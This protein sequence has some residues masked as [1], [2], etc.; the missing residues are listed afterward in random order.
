MALSWH[1]RPV[2][3]RRSAPAAG[4]PALAG[5]GL[6]ARRGGLVRLR[7]H[8]AGR[9]RPDVGGYGDNPLDLLYYDL[10]L[11]VLGSP[12]LDAGGPF[13]PP[14][15][16]A[17]FARAGRHRVRA[18]RG[19]PAAVRHR[20]AP[21]ARPATPAGTSS[22][23]ATRWSPA[24]STRRLRA[25][26]ERVVDRAAPTRSRPSRARAGWRGA[27]RDPDVL[28]AAG[29]GRARALYACT[30]DSAANTAIALAAARPR[31]GRPPLAVYAQVADPE[32]CAALQARLLERAR[33]ARRPAGLL[34]HRR[35]GRPASWSP[36]EPLRRRGR[37]RPPPGGDPRRHRVRPGGAGRAG[38]ARG[39]SAT[40]AA[41]A[42]AGDAGRPGGD[43]G[44]GPAD[45]ALPV[46]A[47]VCRIMPHDD[48]PRAAARRRRRS[49]RLPPDRV[50][51]CYDDEQQALKAALTAE[52]LLARRPGLGGRPAGPAGQPARGVRQRT[53]GSST[54]CP[55]RCGSS[56][57]CTPRATPALIGDDLVERLARVI[58]ERYVV[59]L[60][61]RGERPAATRRWC[62]GTSCPS[63]CGGPTGPRPRTSAASCGRSAARCRRGSGRA[64]STRWPRPRSSGWR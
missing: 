26:G 17:R 13:P 60:R 27:A 4:R 44:G 40:R 24:R 8:R 1:G 6:R 7:L 51:I 28:R 5:A 58:H 48:G 25:A 64:A 19:R 61:R 46:P 50:F 35:P 22:S 15:D 45:R 12:P 62:P 32:V 9:I 10:Q 59:D 33:H 29:V 39:G 53:T 30:D 49:G 56:A 55:A 34:Q 21:A 37:G 16:I 31:H 18:G 43:R 11:F 38:P 42:A 14:L 57:W 3:H 54:T 52:Q 23:A 47:R 41:P 2:R 63:R 36:Q 20:A